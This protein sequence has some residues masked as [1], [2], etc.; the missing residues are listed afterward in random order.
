MI[1][2]D[3]QL[4]KAILMSYQENQ[5]V[6]VDYN[7][8]KDKIRVD[9]IPVGLQNL[10]NT[11]YFNSLLQMYFMNHQLVREILLFKKPTNS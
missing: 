11:C 6:S 8:P 10:G 4:N 5:N 1:N 7:S 3:E 9:G 2:E